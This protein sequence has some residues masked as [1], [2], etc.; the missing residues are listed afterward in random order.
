MLG[1]MLILLL[2]YHRRWETL[3]IFLLV[4]KDP[5]KRIHSSLVRKC[6]PILPHPGGTETQHGYLPMWM[7]SKMG[8]KC[9]FSLMTFLPVILAAIC[10]GSGY[11]ILSAFQVMMSLFIINAAK[12][13]K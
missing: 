5:G 9:D 8:R 2:Q 1:V 6:C 4:K 11:R 3:L 10:K 12:S 13:Q 7:I